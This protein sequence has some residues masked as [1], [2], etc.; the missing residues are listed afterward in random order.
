MLLHFLSCS[1]TSG[2]AFQRGP[3][4]NID[5]V[6]SASFLCQKYCFCDFLDFKLRVLKVI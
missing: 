4:M 2:E 1:N 5:F 3:F 6:G